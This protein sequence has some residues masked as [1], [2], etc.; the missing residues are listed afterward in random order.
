MTIPR[1]SCDASFSARACP[2]FCALKIDLCNRPLPLVL[3]MRVMLRHSFFV[4]TILVIAL[5][6]EQIS[7]SLI[8]HESCGVLAVLEITI[9][10]GS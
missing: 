10:C 6:V 2:F 1:Q 3:F 4:C 7:K 8:S 5:N 9:Y